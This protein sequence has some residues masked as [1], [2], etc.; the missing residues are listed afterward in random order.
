MLKGFKRFLMH[1]NIIVVAIGLVVAL[2]FSN[3][4]TAFTTNVIDPLVSRAQGNHSMGLGV[5]LGTSGNTATFVNFGA[6][7]S[8]II[9]FFVF[10]FVV[11]FAIVVP[12]RSIQARRGQSVFG[13]PP[14]T[15][16][17]PECLQSDLPAAATRCWHCTA[18]QP[19]PPGTPDSSVAAGVA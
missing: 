3:L 9:Y 5:Q 16:T 8:A 19:V 18:V 6:L 1:G 10:M 2:A 12:Y 7:I 14:P 4:V 15:K 17:C 11:Y 13:D